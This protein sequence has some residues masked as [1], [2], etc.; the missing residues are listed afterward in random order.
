M[1]GLAAKEHVLMSALE[2]PITA[3]A[4]VLSFNLSCC[5]QSSLKLALWVS[6][7]YIRTQESNQCK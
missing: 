2:A 7:T 1:S 3:C 4:N 5:E 6:N